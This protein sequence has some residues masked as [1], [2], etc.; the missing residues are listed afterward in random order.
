MVWVLGGLISLVGALCYAEL[1]SAFPS[2]GGDYHF[3]KRAFGDKLSFLFA[4]ARMTV[5]Q[6]GSAAILSFIF[7]D[8]ATQ[9]YSL[10]EFSPMIYAALVIAVLTGIN[11]I[12]I[13]F[14]AGVQKLLSTLQIAGVVSIIIAGL[15]FAPAEGEAAS[16]GGNSR[17][18]R[19]S[20]VKHLDD[21]ELG[22][23]SLADEPEL[24]AQE[25]LDLL[26]NPVRRATLGQKGQAFAGANYDWQ[27]LIPRLERIYQQV[28]L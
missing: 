10:G 12:G 18:G 14:G 17:G 8:Y 28:S 13:Q 24:F 25:L 19:A 22:E 20:I 6:T 15:F 3:L 27:I 21:L 2:A 1:A 9:L 23:F 7:G 5:I 11:I 4:W 16:P 26:R